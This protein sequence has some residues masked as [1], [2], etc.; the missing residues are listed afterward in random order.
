MRVF[1]IQDPAEKAAAQQ[2]LDAAAQ[3]NREPQGIDVDH[4]R[5]AGGPARVIEQDAQQ[6][7]VAVLHGYR[8]VCWKHPHS[9]GDVVA[10]W[11]G[12]DWRP[13]Y[14]HAALDAH[15]HNTTAHRE[16]N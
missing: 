1:G 10:P 13:A 5:I 2:A 12:A 8:A 7:G 4:G 9:P 16:E 3:A 11:Q 15:E 6:P 14:I